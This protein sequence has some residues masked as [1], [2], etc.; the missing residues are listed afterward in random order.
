MSPDTPNSDRDQGRE[1]WVGIPDHLSIM[2]DA[3]AWWDGRGWED[4]YRKLVKR[5][6]GGL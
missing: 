4:E 5:S 3:A 2:L 1:A 6:G